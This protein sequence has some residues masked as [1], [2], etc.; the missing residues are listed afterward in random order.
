M[1]RTDVLDRGAPWVELVARGEAPPD[2]LNLGARNRASALAA[3]GI[4]A[5]AL[6]RRPRVAL[7]S[8]LGLLALNR[9]LYA[10]LRARLGPSR[11]VA[12]VGLHVV[13]LLSA[14]ASVP[15]GLLAAASGRGRRPLPR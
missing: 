15:L 3:L 12:G 2:E 11:A 9:E 5:A 14:V 6:A 10:L 8:L 7:L 13:H 4:A 1:I